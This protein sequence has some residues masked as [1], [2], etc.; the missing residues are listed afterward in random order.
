MQF[1]DALITVLKKLGFDYRAVKP[2][3]TKIL[4]FRQ[5]MPRKTGR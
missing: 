1:G 5:K 3:E 2:S 4:E